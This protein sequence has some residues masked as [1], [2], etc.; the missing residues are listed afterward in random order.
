VLIRPPWSTLESHQDYLGN[1]CEA[2]IESPRNPSGRIL[3]RPGAQ[4]GHGGGAKLETPIAPDG[5]DVLDADNDLQGLLADGLAT[6]SSGVCW[7]LGD[8]LGD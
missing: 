4:R 8:P 2:F 6:G 1:L 3:A 7:L 5:L